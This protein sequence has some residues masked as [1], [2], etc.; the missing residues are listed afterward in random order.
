MTGGVFGGVVRF[1]LN[2]APVTVLLTLLLV[3]AGVAFAPFAWEVGVPRAPVPVDAIPDLGDNQ[4]IVFVEWPGYAPADVERQV[5]YPLATSLLGMQGVRTVR[6]TSMFGFASIYVIFDA[7]TAFYE[8]RAR[9]LEKLSSLPRDLLPEGVR[10]ALGPDATALG[11]VYWYTLEAHD[12]EGRVVAGAFDRHELRELQDFVIR[13]ALSAVPGVAEVSSIGG[14]VAEYQVE[15][16]PDLLRAHQLTLAEVEGAVRSA[17]LDV[18]ARTIEVQS[19]EYVV[20]GL[21]L[22]GSVEDLESAVVAVRDGTSLRVRDVAHVTLGPATRRGALDDAGAEVVGGIV[23]VRYGENPLAVIGRVKE[24]V[25]ELAPGLPSREVSGRQARVTL[26]PFY[27]RTEL[28]N[29]TLDTLSTAL[30]QQLVITLLVVLVMLGTIRGAFVVAL[31]L[32]LGV[33]C[34]FVGMGVFGVDANVMALGGIAIAIG[35][36]VDVGIVFTE[37]V[38]QRLDETAAS[39]AAR[40]EVVVA[41]VAEV[42]PA[43]LT[44]VLTTVVSFLPVFGLTDA[45]GKLFTPLAWTKT[46]A[47]LGAFAVGLL[48][49]PVCSDWLFRF[50]ARVARPWLRRV[51]ILGVALALALVLSEDW[52]P[53]GLG[54]G[55]VSS[56]V[57]VAVVVGGLLSLFELFRR[58]YPR[59]LDAA[60]RRPVLFLTMPAALV[61]AGAIAWKGIPSFLGAEVAARWTGLR[62]ADVPPFDEGAFLYMPTTTPHASFGEAL[63]LLQAMD[64]AIAAVPE[65]ERVVGKLGRAESALDPAPVSMFETMV[66][67]R[68]E[69]GVDAQGQRVRQWRDHIR[70]PGDVW[71]EIARAAER[72]GLTGAPMLQPIGTRLVMLQTGMRGRVGLKVRGPDLMALE[73]FGRDAERVL[74]GVETLRPA[75]VQAERSVGKPYLEMVVDREA[76]ARYGVTVATAQRTFAAAIGGQLVGYALEG[77][78]RR[79]VRV[80]FAR[81][82]RGTPSDL[83]AVPVPLPGGGTVPLGELATLR[84]ERGPQM[85]R[86]EDGFLTSFVIFDPSEGVTDVDAV[87]DARD[88]LERAIREGTLRVPP[89]VSW[90]LDGTWKNQERASARL[91]VLVPLAL[92]LILLLLQL[93]FRNLAVSLAIGSGVVVAMAGGFLLFALWGAEIWDVSTFG[94][95]LEVLFQTRDEPLTAAVWVGFIALVGIA[96]DDGV[97][98]ATYLDEVFRSAPRDV[99]EVRAKVLEAG[100][101]RV[102]PCLMT[103]ATTLL[104]LLPVLTATGRGSDIMRPMAVPVFGGMAVELLTLF[105]VPVLW[106]LG[107]RWKLRGGRGASVTTP[108]S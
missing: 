30:R 4:Q 11:Q 102:R 95:T 75:S 33:L 86:A 2:N 97:M 7:S 28:I 65:V 82:E 96:V 35:T 78:A 46:F 64:G 74:R 90:V 84:Y 83:E 3:G 45:E 71:L 25:A 24:R 66:F 62:P 40:R 36:M 5:T 73:R 42:A 38:K 44:S 6:S 63:D 9:L 70:T 10:P 34:A 27:D 41:A 43:I 101:R 79:A 104:A 21:G 81:E 93:Q 77:R 37:N 23:V 92:L 60:L 13:P 56:F 16:D 89:G 80:R 12:A 53:L 15:V 17:N 47:L 39:G 50:R 91:M 106:S 32:P 18:G 1:F 22:I 100:T 55:R 105:V 59:L 98:I 26:V 49:V 20:R 48:V 29:E 19:V 54:A 72:P 14:H 52:R 76:L 8:S 87:G 107:W 88:A 103:T 61:V 31:A 69:F 108:L 85:L 51:A 58:V 94:S 68:P 99:E 67:Y 57:F